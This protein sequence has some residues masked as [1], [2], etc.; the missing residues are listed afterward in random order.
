MTQSGIE[1]LLSEKIGLDANSIG[2]HHIQRTIERRMADCAITNITTYLEHLQ[3]S[4]EEWQALI[5][6]IVVPETWF[7]RE[8]KA[9]AFLKN[10]HPV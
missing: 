3:N 5:E 7:F 6:S 10:L 9:F 8:Q 2:S 1:S 4:S